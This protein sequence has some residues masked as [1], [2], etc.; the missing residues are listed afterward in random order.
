M[1][2][3]QK[4]VHPWHDTVTLALASGPSIR[5]AASDCDVG[6][7]FHEWVREWRGTLHNKVA[8]RFAA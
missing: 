6:E 7:R 2:L 5:E 1:N 4:Q 8:G 3:P